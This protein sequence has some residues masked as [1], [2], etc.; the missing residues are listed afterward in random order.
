MNQTR[1]AVTTVHRPLDPILMHDYVETNRL[2]NIE[3]IP[4]ILETH[5]K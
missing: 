4:E 1:S 3:T 2:L 5:D